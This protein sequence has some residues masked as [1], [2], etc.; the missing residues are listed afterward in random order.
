MVTRKGDPRG[1]RAEVARHLRASADA[2]ADA[3]LV[4]VQ[5]DAPAG[6]T[7]DG[8]TL[9][10]LH[11]GARAAVEYFLARLDAGA[12]ADARGGAG[13]SGSDTA[14]FEAHGRAQ[15]AA[16]R[17]LSELLAFYRLGG[18]AMWE[19]AQ[20]LPIS[21]DL[22]PEAIFALGAEV[23][24]A[25]DALSVAALAGFT[26]QEAETL[27]RE[28]ARRERLA[29][30][31]LSDRPSAPEALAAAAAAADWSL[32]AR[33]RVAVAALPI[34]PPP[35]VALA[36]PARVLAATV[37]GGRRAL[38]VAD[39]DECERWLMRAAQ[40]QQLEPPLAVG[41]AVAPAEA[42]RSLTR[43]DALLDQAGVLRPASA[44]AARPDAAAEVAGPE[45]APFALLR[46]DDHEIDL[47]LSAAPELAR[48]IA[49]RR[50]A[51]LETLPERQRERLLETL[52][53]WLAHPVRP[54]AIA[55]ELGVHVQ[56][57]RYRL[58]QLRE[59]LGDALDAPDA[60]FELS[61]ALRARAL[62]GD[63]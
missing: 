37:D 25:V 56:T 3:V 6:A 23:L 18:L 60:R 11:V 42:A 30:L 4:R 45:P 41:P 52:A 28:L 15:Q 40:A 14:L 22:S 51:P 24:A 27:R 33:V 62:N 19:G 53:G 57:V 32:P 47:L 50:L 55:D 8:A 38:V 26:A 48:A 2:L 54:Q 17:S 58:N 21:R 12:A 36:G 46:C 49:Q 13:G 20:S 29:S 35:G 34:E 39:D 16:G 61:V 31:L 59:L 63:G 5:A 7:P 43:A 44:S 1:A 10:N 9:R